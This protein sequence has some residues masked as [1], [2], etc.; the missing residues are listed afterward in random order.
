MLSIVT[1]ET[2]TNKITKTFVKNSSLTNILIDWEGL[3][4]DINLKNNNA[5][6]ISRFSTTYMDIFGRV[7]IT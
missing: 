2:I 5:I 4:Y 6:V 7:L 3:F 1:A